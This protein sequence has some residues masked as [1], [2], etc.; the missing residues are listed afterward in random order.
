MTRDATAG[1]ITESKL[2]A[3]RPFVFAE[4]DFP[5]GFV[6]L[7]STDRTIPFD[8][9]SGV[10]GFLGAG[11]MGSVSSIGEVAGLRAQG[12][13]LS[14]SG[15]PASHISLAFE[16]AQRR[17][18]KVWIAFLD[19]N[20]TLVSDPVLAFSGLIDSS[21]FLTYVCLQRVQNRVSLPSYSHS[22][23]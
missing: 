3:P 4:L 20:Y 9:G 11:A 15:I 14:L 21:S 5:T 13:E 12:V 16:N 23:I 6:R 2:E 18:G 1:A 17:T 8:S 19:S 10:E 7:N 22:R